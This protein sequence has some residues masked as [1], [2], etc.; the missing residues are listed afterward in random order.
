MGLDVHALRFLLEAR[1]AGVPMGRTATLGRQSLSVPPQL[2]ARTLSEYGLPTSEADAH[3]LIAK[4]GGY[5]DTLMIDKLGVEEL[6]SFD[7]S[8]YEQATVIHDMNQPIDERFYAQFDL[9]IDGG[10][11]EH[12][13]HFP[14]AIKNALSMV[15]QGGRFVMTAPANNAMGHGFYQFSP[16][17]LYR[18]CHPDNGFKVERMQIL[19]LR[20]FR[21]RLF[22]VRDPADVHD[23]V[24][25][26]ESRNPAILY[27]QAI[28]TEIVPI[29]AVTPQQSDYS[30]R[31]DDHAAEPDKDKVYSRNGVGQSAALFLR[32]HIHHPLVQKLM[33]LR[34]KGFHRD[35]FSPRYF[36]RVR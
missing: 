19:D 9:V 27:V 4:S 10:T 7:A 6:T 2:L 26:T 1:K 36:R 12:V 5:V 16:E 14:T 20:L 3:A 33:W 32:R 31:W 28:R 29:F 25:V 18:V 21:P 22:D 17:L 35:S 8:D 34:Y 30:E 15:K 23:R 24:M 13:F 11:L